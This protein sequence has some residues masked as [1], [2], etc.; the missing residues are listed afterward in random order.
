MTAG[1]RQAHLHAGAS[2][3]LVTGAGIFIRMV[4][5]LDRPMVTRGTRALHSAACLRVTTGGRLAH[6]E[7]IP[8]VV[9]TAVHLKL[10]LKEG[11][12]VFVM[13]DKRCAFS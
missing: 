6:P 10:D 7:V 11:S 9:T 13:A 1:R 12:G 5:P 2:D 4:P 8:T 3:H